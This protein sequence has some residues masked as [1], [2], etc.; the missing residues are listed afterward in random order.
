MA[1]TDFAVGKALKPIHVCSTLHL[2]MQ[3]FKRGFYTDVRVKST[4]QSCSFK[5]VNEFSYP[6]PSPHL[7]TPTKELEGLQ[8]KRAIELLETF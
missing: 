3:I 4:V 6:I 8:V 1:T 5:Q 2:Y 7:P